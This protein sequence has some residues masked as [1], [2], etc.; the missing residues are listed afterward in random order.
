MD[1][2]QLNRQLKA[3][4]TRCD[5]VKYE[6]KLLTTDFQGLKD[7]V[8]KT[9]I[10]SVVCLVLRITLIQIFLNSKDPS[11]R[12]LG[13]F[14]APFDYFVF[15]VAFI[16]FAVKGFD[17]FINADFK[18]SKMAA[19]KLSK[20]TVTDKLNELNSEIARLELEINKTETSLYEQGGKI[21]IP[22]QS[23]TA[24][25]KKAVASVE[26]PQ[27]LIKPAVYEE[28]VEVEKVEPV[29]TGRFEPKGMREETHRD[30]EKNYFAESGHKNQLDEILNGLDDFSVE[31]EDEFENSSDLWEQD[32]MK[33]YR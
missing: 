19:K 2:A 4:N 24:V 3:L 6:K 25:Q 16:L 11:V 1:N 21:D 33:H 20:S 31:D 29:I 23:N 26:E 12:A 13:R 8:F 5:D 18:Y 10:I 28:R 9:G 27:I 15:L 22:D 14:L 32:A 7:F 30:E 17:L